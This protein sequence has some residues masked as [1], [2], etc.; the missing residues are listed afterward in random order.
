MYSIIITTLDGKEECFESFE[1][2]VKYSYKYILH[3]HDNKP[4]YINHRSVDKR[5]E[6]WF[7]RNRL[8]CD[9]GP[10][11]IHLK[12]NVIY[13]FQYW[14][15]GR[16]LSAIQFLNTIKEVDGMCPALQLLDDREWVRERAKRLK[17]E[18]E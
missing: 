3:S 4:A 14:I 17:K 11:I 9:S 15:E 1:Q 8:H 10:A 18:D 16:C 7:Y 2:Y 5:I 6:S 12:D 13:E